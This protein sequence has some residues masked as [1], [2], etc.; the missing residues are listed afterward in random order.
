MS[1]NLWLK[2]NWRKPKMWTDEKAT[3]A[4]ALYLEY[5]GE[6][7]TDEAKAKNT[8]EV[9][10]RVAEEVGEKVN[11][12]RIRLS[13]ADVWVKAAPKKAVAATTEGKAKRV[14]KAEAIAELESVISANGYTVTAE[15]KA[16][17]EKL[18]GKAAVMFS[19]IIS[20][21]VIEG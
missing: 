2:Q 17:I 9:C 5:I 11:S 19:G 18:T 10:A 14:N 12:V 21:I 1:Y 20:T 7:D 8:M 6:F 16:I 4:V 3:T 15:D 13:K